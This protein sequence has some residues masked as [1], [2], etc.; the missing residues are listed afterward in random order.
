MNLDTKRTPTRTKS[1]YNTDYAFGNYQPFDFFCQRDERIFPVG[2][3]RE[4]RRLLPKSGQIPRQAGR[5]PHP[6]VRSSS[7]APVPVPHGRSGRERRRAT[8][9]FR[10]L[11]RCPTPTA[12]PT[13]A[14]S[15]PRAG[16]KRPP[17]ARAR[18]LRRFPPRPPIRMTIQHKNAGLN[19]PHSNVYPP[20][21]LVSLFRF[22]FPQPFP[23]HPQPLISRYALSATNAHKR[24]RQII[25]RP[26]GTH[27]RFACAHLD[28][29][30]HVD[31]PRYECMFSL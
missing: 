19:R 26:T 21:F 22:P 12:A 30:K 2:R 17:A 14:R 7:A 4:T 18:L 25:A 15:A 10:T 11:P 23:H 1:L 31:S 29:G 27:K 24:P 3:V 6:A 5:P 9:D 20:I 13:S 8:A 16:A 28:P